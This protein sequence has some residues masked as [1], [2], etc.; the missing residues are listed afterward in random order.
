MSDRCVF[1]NQILFH[2]DSYTCI[3]CEISLL[4]KL[5]SPRP[6]ISTPFTCVCVCKC[7]YIYNTPCV[8][9]YHNRYFFFVE[10]S[11]RGVN[12]FF[13]SSLQHASS[14]TYIQTRKP[15]PNKATMKFM[16]KFRH[17]HIIVSVLCL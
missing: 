15:V 13:F 7:L 11:H 5:T 4:A 12:F 17:E 3:L 14:D 8:P 9:A 16:F 2:P 6:I 10:C 1:I